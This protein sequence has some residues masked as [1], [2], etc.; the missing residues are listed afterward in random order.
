MTQSKEL[1]LSKKLDAL[2]DANS[3][4]GG[5]KVPY[6]PEH[7]DCW[8][9]PLDKYKNTREKSAA[10]VSAS[11]NNNYAIDSQGNKKPVKDF[12]MSQLAFVC[13]MWRV[14]KKLAWPIQYI[15]GQDMVLIRKIPNSK[16]TLFDFY[17]GKAVKYNC[18]GPCIIKD[19][20]YDFIVAKYETDEKT[21]WTYGKSVQEARAFMEMKLYEEYQDVINAIA[22]KNKNRGK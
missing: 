20:N 6:I 22:R 15:C 12:D 14:Q 4:M 3:T 5:I 1:N 9:N 10:W 21:Y 8:S 19:H 2:C 11:H 7:N 13:G 16:K 17:R 18:Y